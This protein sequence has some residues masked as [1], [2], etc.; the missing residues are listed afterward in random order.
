MQSLEVQAAGKE[1]IPEREE[2]G[3]TQTEQ[4]KK[5]YGFNTPKEADASA[6]VSTVVEIA[7]ANGL[8]PYRC[9]KIFLIE[10]PYL[11]KACKFRSV[12]TTCTEVQPRHHG[13]IA[14]P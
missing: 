7:K 9:L 1:T 10:L 8:E 5:C 3:R 11:D 14:P 13:K 4:Y 12:S 2:S 6:I